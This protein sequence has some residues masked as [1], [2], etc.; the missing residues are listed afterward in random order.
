MN[1]K[2]RTDFRLVALDTTEYWSDEIKTAA[3]RIIEVFVV[4]ANLHTHICSLSPSLWLDPVDFWT[5]NDIDDDVW[6]DIQQ[7]AS[8]GDYYGLDV[9]NNPNVKMGSD[10]F[11]HPKSDE[12]YQERVEEILE[13]CRCNGGGNYSWKLCVKVGLDNE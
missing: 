12:L 7:W 3:G 4:N 2:V 1:N 13:H 5:K 9:L 10:N 6:S 11:Y 8:D